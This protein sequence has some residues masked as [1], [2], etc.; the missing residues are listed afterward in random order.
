MVAN[1]ENESKLD[2]LLQRVPVNELVERMNRDGLSVEEMYNI[3][4]SRDE[5]RLDTR[6]ADLDRFHLTSK[7]SGKVTGVF[8]YAIFV[9]I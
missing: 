1:T 7:E 9:Y 4:K 6:P 2:F 5:Q 3:L 8:D